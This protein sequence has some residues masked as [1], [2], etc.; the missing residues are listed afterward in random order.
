MNSGRTGRIAV[1][2]PPRRQHQTRSVV[3]CKTCTTAC[4]NYEDCLPQPCTA[5]RRAGADQVDFVFGLT[6]LLVSVLRD[7]CY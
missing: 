7:C 1:S 6:L 4:L 3:P 2:T 5:P